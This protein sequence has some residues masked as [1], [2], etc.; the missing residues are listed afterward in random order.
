LPNVEGDSEH[1][2]VAEFAQGIDLGRAFYQELVA[3]RLAGRRHSAARLGPG[4]DVLGYDTPRFTDH[5]WGAHLA[6]L[7]EQG[8]PYPLAGVPAEF[9]GWP[10]EVVV[11]GIGTF[12]T[13]QLGWPGIPASC[14]CGSWPAN[15]AGSPRRSPSRAGPPRPATSSASGCWWPGWSMT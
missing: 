3:P 13:W 15:G 1:K 12:L 8:D 7:V 10:T 4:S 6:V 9:R 14:G 11:V 5:G 2:I